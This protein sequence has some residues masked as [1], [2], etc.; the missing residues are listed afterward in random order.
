LE[1]WL[2]PLG[3]KRRRDKSIWL[4][5]A[6]VRLGCDPTADDFARPSAGDI[7]AFIRRIVAW[8]EDPARSGTSPT[9]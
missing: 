8:V 5:Q 3:P 7:W 1:D 4:R 9:E 6:L 2:A